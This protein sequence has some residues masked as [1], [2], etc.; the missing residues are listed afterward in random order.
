MISKRA[1][2]KPGLFSEC[3]GVVPIGVVSAETMSVVE[4]G[5][6]SAVTVDI[7]VTVVLNSGLKVIDTLCVVFGVVSSLTVVASLTVALVVTL[8]SC[9]GDVGGTVVMFVA[10]VSPWISVVFVGLVGDKT[11]FSATEELR[12]IQYTV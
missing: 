4:G 9:E 1:G 6:S 12:D 3:C 10:T 8:A 7:S 2:D 11:D 5:R